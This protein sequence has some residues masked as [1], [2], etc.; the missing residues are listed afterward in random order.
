MRQQA[1]VNSVVALKELRAALAK[2]AETASAAL[3]EVH[4]DI[5][6]TQTWLIEDRRRHWKNQVRL[7]QERYVQAKLALKRK[8]IF[9]LALA[10]A[11]TSAID[12]KKALAIAERQLREAERREARTR[13][14]ILQLEKELSD[15]RAAT[16]GLSGAIDTNIPN[17]RARLEK[18]V[19]SLEAYVALAP[20]EE[21]PSSDEEGLGTEASSVQQPVSP[22]PETDNDT[23]DESPE[24]PQE[25]AS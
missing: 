23:E 19:E 2:F 6:R 22:S 13:S 25:K 17:A 5:Q 12:E 4:S 9:D 11:R 10:G 16:Q 1:K 20:P 8:G 3:D 14:W 15:Y 7:R 21:T 24:E 18:M